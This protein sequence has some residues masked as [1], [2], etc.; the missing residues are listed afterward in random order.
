MLLTSGRS[1]GEA[2]IHRIKL[3]LDSVDIT[4]SKTIENSSTGD[5]NT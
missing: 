3:T 1:V 5:C 2:S 4:A